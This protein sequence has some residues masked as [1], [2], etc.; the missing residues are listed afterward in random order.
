MSGANG[1][2]SALLAGYLSRRYTILF[3][4][5]LFTLVASPVLSSLNFSGKM[6]ELLLAASLLAAVLPVNS[7]RSRGLAGASG[8]GVARSSPHI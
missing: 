4:S 8:D 2:L 5:L 3:Y 1:T 6:I 7:V